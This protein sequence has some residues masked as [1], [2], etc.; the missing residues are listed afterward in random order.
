M[1]AVV[2]VRGAPAAGAPSSFGVFVQLSRAVRHAASPDALRF[3]IV[4]ETRRL[5]AYRQAALLLDHGDGALRVAALS[6]VPVVERQALLVRWL[7]RAAATVIHHDPVAARLHPLDTHD[8]AIGPVLSEGR[9]SFGSGVP[10]WCPLEA[11]DGRSLGVLWLDRAEPWHEAEMLLL[12]ELTDV[13][14]HALAALSH[15]PVLRWRRPSLALALAC[16]AVAGLLAPVNRAALAP[17][18]IVAR[19]PDVVAAPI[20][21]VVRAFQVAPNQ[22]VA[23]GEPLFTLDDT[24]RRGRVEVAEKTLD[25]ARM[26]YR[27][28][29]QGALGGRRDAP[30]LAALE[31]AIALKEVELENARH[32]LERTQARAGH[33]GL[34]VLPDPQ[35]WLGRP[36][37]TGERVMLIAD[38][39]DVQAIAW[40][41]VHDVL[42]LVEGASVR[43]F[44]DAD[45]LAPI[46]G[47]LERAGHEPEEVPG[48]TLAY[49]L[50]V[51]LDTG[52][53]RPPPRIGLKGTARIEGDRVALAFYLFRRPLAALRQAIGF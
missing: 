38:P 34:V 13:Q 17:V 8:T 52:G 37:A 11:R 25:V 3:S 46:N 32:Q 45:P 15:R 10:L 21:G 53:E 22:R 19:A 24:D 40:L 5:V 39:A 7:E 18:E 51:T 48:G 30:R 47:R 4:N 49:R 29:S 31:A 41:P 14:A 43:L 2:D 50:T 6:G 1:S 16:A 44:L 9:T 36:V 42:P 27:Q 33:G 20:D 23:A 26:E 12:A 28:A 35:E